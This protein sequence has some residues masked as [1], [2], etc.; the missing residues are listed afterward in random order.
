MGGVITNTA[1][2]LIAL[3]FFLRAMNAVDSER[4]S[5]E[6]EGLRRELRARHSPVIIKGRQMGVSF[7]NRLISQYLFKSLEK[8]GGAIPRHYNC[9]SFIEYLDE[10]DFV[11]L[12]TES[13]LDEDDLVGEYS[14]GELLFEFGVK[15]E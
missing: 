4:K 11:E 12:P 8:S 1:L 6:L 15:G 5:A 13:T 3:A 14:L 2:A 7:T 9:G 10:D